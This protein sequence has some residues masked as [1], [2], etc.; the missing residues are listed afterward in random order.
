MTFRRETLSPRTQIIDRY[1]QACGVRSPRNNDPYAVVSHV[2]GLCGEDG[3]SKKP[4]PNYWPGE[5]H[6]E[7]EFV[8]SKC[9]FEES[10]RA[11]EALSE[12]ERLAYLR[13]INAENR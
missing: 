3:A 4:H 8:H 12:D 5:R 7:T 11:H 10:L 13:T 1:S 6:P 9:E 2:C